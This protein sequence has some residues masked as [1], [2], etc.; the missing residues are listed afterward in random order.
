[1]GANLSNDEA[2]MIYIQNTD[3]HSGVSIDSLTYTIGAPWPDGAAGLGFS[4]ELID[5]LADNSDPINWRNAIYYFGEYQGYEIYASPGTGPGNLNTEEEQLVEPIDFYPNPVKD[6]LNIAS[7]TELIKV[8]IYSLL[9]NKI[10]ELRSGLNSIKTSNL[11]R[12]IYIVKIYSENNCTTLK[13][14]KN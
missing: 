3:H 12:G 7:K 14:I 2:E 1:M 9:G 5:P 6:V 8:E 13:M 10:K 4:M 11:S